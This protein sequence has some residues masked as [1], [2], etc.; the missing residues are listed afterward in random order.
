MAWNNM[1][2]I[3]LYIFG[4]VLYLWFICFSFSPCTRACASMWRCLISSDSSILPHTAAFSQDLAGFLHP[5]NLDPG[6]KTEWQQ[7]PRDGNSAATRCQN[8]VSLEKGTEWGTSTKLGTHWV[9]KHLLDQHRKSVFNRLSL[10]QGNQE[11]STLQKHIQTN[12]GTK[13]RGERQK[14]LRGGKKQ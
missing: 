8:R 3:S 11:R 5:E 2:Q 1:P 9:Y 13:S 7:W 4:H 14:K 6:L 12:D 10:S